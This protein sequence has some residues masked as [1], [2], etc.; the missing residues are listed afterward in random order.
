MNYG[1]RKK[2]TLCTCSFLL[3]ISKTNPARELAIKLKTRMNTDWTKQQQYQ[4]HMD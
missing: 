2:S 3:F 1:G 4:Q